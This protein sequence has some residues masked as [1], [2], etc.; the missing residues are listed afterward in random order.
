MPRYSQPAGRKIATCCFCGTRAVLILDRDRHELS[1]ANCGAPLHDLKSFPQPT[2]KTRKKRHTPVTER[3]LPRA[4][5]DARQ[6]K[7]PRGR[8]AGARPAKKRRKPVFKRLWE[9]LWD[10]IEDIFD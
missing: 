3:R 5:Q 9:E 1:C 7:P 8:A 10:E 6:D 4:R 2:D